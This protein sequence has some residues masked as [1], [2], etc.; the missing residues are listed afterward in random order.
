MK[1]FRVSIPTTMILALVLFAV[2]MQSEVGK[3][4]TP[5]S[6][7]NGLLD[8]N[9]PGLDARC[10]FAKVIGIEELCARLQLKETMKDAFKEALNESG[11]R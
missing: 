9:D 1:S 2:G 11:I 5:V 3:T 7:V 6:Y 4:I 10:H 8:P